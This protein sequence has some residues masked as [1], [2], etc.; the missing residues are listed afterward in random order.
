MC[1]CDGKDL[2][3]CVYDGVCNG[4]GGLVVHG[5]C[6]GEGGCDYTVLCAGLAAVA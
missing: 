1:V 2:V 6:D 3:V 4:G 5:V